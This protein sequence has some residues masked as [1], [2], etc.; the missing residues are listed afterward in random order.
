MQSRKRF[1]YFLLLNLIVSA[2]TT[3]VVVTLMLRNYSLVSI[4]APFLDSG[5][6]SQ[7]QGEPVGG[8]ADQPVTGADTSGEVLVFP[9]QLEINSIIGAG[10]IE[11]ER[12]LMRHVGDEEISMMGWQLQDSDGNTFTFPALTMFGGGA[13]TIYTKSGLDT[14]VEMYWGLDQSVWEEGEQA[15][16]LDPNG[17]VYVV[18]TV[19]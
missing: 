9:G 8:D 11:N 3:W 19:P 15:R 2:L 6:A 7:D 12:V 13:V 10:D 1:L 17:N 16:L 14:V 18:Y 4:P 5:D